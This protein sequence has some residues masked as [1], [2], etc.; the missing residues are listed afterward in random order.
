MSSISS[1]FPSIS[2]PSAQA[3][4]VSALETSSRQLSLA[5]QQIADP[6]NQN[7]INPLLDANQSG[8]I[9]DAGVAVIKAS[10]Q[11]LGALLDIFA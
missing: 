10:N 6:D 3:S 9:A 7:L 11:R 1:I 4:G 5:A 2:I 8:L